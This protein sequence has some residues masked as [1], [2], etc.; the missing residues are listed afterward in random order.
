M[1]CILTQE[2][3]SSEECIRECWQLPGLEEARKGLSST[4][5]RGSEGP[6]DALVL[7]QWYRFQTPG[8]QNVRE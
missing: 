7:A 5:P 1:I 6:A 8:L 3:Y 2:P 4:A